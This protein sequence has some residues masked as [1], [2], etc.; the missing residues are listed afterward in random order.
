MICSDHF[1]EMDLI[2]GENRVKIRK[3]AYPTR[4]KKRLK[5][6]LVDHDYCAPKVIDEVV[7]SDHGYSDP[8]PPKLKIKEMETS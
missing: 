8:N 1:E 4:F 5:N 7:V 3:F 6:S 2:H